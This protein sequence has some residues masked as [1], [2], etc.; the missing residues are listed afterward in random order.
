MIVIIDNY[1]SYVYNLA[2]AF[3]VHCDVV[4]VI[5]NDAV[6]IEELSK[7][8][9]KL[10]VISPGPGRPENAGISLQCF[11]YFAGQIPIFGVCLG[12]QCM[13]VAF[14]GSLNYARVPMH[15]KVSSLEH[16]NEGIFSSISSNCSVVRYNSLIVNESCVEIDDLKVTAWSEAG[17]VMALTHNQYC[18]NAVQFHPESFDTCCGT[19]LISNVYK[20]ACGYWSE[21]DGK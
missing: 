3:G 9:I 15:G 13:A 12:L 16:S 6:S 11:K 19:Q 2:H 20:L 10:L 14:G 1:D 17:E 18:V 7:L 5:A 21:N 8:P 4:K